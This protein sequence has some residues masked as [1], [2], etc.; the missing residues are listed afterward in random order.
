MARKTV[1]S[2]P[3]GKLPNELLKKFLDRVRVEDKQVV[4]GAAI[5]E[6]A[7][8]I[9]IGN[10]LLVAKTDPVTLASDHIGWYAVHINANDVAT[11]G[12]RPRWFMA[13]VLLPEKST[14]QEAEKIFDQMLSAC[15]SLEVSLVGG[16]TEVTYDLKRPII[17]GCMLAEAEDRP[18]ITTSGARPGDDIVLTKGVAIEGTAAL[19][20]EAEKALLDAGLDRDLIQRATDYLFTPGISVVKEALLASARV[21][22]HSMHDPTE[23]GL[24][25]G[26]QEIAM[27]ARV[28]ILIEEERI[29]ILP[30][31]KTICERLA[32]SPLGLLASGALI[33]T[34]P[35][36]ETP[37]LLGALYQAKINASLIGKVV[38]AKEGLKMH[39]RGGMQAFPSF[40]RD[41]LARFLDSQ[42]SDKKEG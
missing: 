5:G 12:V 17:V 42:T 31:C 20:R 39:T 30:E 18:I 4:L 28:G 38:R 32:L 40:E 25:T 9:R 1:K 24:S 14:L 26:L 34:L 13:S 21:K 7:A 3:V 33:I 8:V 2:L 10:R 16:H 36:S 29:P 6:D 37:K 23:G 19:A 15:D 27:A 22:V 11:R 35:P 41:E